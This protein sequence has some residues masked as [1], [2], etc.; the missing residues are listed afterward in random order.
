MSKNIWLSPTAKTVA[1]ANGNTYRAALYIFELDR[2]LFNKKAKASVERGE[3]IGFESFL[4]EKGYALFTDNETVLPASLTNAQI[5]YVQAGIHGF[6]KEQQNVLIGKGYITAEQVS[7]R[8]VRYY[9]NI[10]NSIAAKYEQLISDTHGNT[11]DFNRDHSNIEYAI[12][13]LNV[14]CAMEKGE[15]R[16][17]L[18]KSSIS[19]LRALLPQFQLFAE[20]EIEP[21]RVHER[22]VKMNQLEKEGK[23]RGYMRAKRDN[24]LRI[25]G[26]EAP[27]EVNVGDN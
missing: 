20:G 7:D 15:E 22:L 2:E 14:G 6:S 5:V 10:L 17:K 21:I 18:I 23:L 4:L 26:M 12:N 27:N 1:I 16:D 3:V 11:H 25:L 8:S 9:S 24:M 19:H 13:R